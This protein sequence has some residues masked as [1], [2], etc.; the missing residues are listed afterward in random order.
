MISTKISNDA[1]QYELIQLKKENIKLIQE[2]QYYKNIGAF[3]KPN[4]P[5][6][7]I[8]KRIRKMRRLSQDKLAKLS[9]LSILSIQ[10]YEKGTCDPKLPCVI[11]LAEALNTT[12]AVLIGEV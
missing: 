3:K 5:F 1:I 9:G 12:V 11:W 7:V 6:G 8:L 4:E 2:N 10:H